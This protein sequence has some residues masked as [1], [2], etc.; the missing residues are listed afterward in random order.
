MATKKK[1]AST[2][3]KKPA[4]TKK[5]AS[6]APKKP[7]TPIAPVSGSQDAYD[8]FLPAAQGLDARDVLVCRA[9]PSLAFHNVDVGV[10]SLLA[11]KARIAKEL[12][13]VDAA[14]LAALPSLA[15]AVAFA[16][17]QVDRS[18][19]ANESL[20]N[21]L[22]E[23]HPLR[24]KLLTAAIALGEAGI[25]PAA[26]VAK[27]QKGVGHI[28]AASD[29]V[30]LASLFARNA[31]AVAGKS[32]IAAADVKRADALGSGLLATLKPSTAKKGNVRPGA[33]AA[34]V[35]DRLW[36]LLVQRHDVARRAGAWLF[37]LSVAEASVP[38]LLSH[39][40]APKKKTASPT[41]GGGAAGKTTAT[42]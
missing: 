16:A 38:P 23:A 21:E 20:A 22:A 4:T 41:P 37:G 8:T 10:A 35:R 2:T 5:T 24:R 30:A 26:E 3:P 17:G 34:D 9:D 14:Q 29:L 36:T 27:I 32:P 18:R 31:K 12:P 40:A 42:T 11:E 15:L 13:T 25:V 7:P 1:T 39:V 33:E 28:D 6:T 19:Q